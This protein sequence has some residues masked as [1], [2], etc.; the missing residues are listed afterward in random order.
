M[1]NVSR[2]V[3]LVCIML[4]GCSWLGLEEHKNQHLQA[5]ETQVIVV[6]ENMSA[7]RLDNSIN[8]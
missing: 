2:L 3:V 5:A 6:P 4:T 8:S 7:S 1:N